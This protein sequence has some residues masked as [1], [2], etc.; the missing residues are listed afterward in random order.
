[1]TA[2]VHVVGTGL[3]GTSV[4][5]ALQ[6]IA[7]VVLSDPDPEARRRSV[8]R[9]AGRA[10]DGA[11][12][13]RL[14]VIASPPSR[15]AG[16]IQRLQRLDVGGTF[17]H[18]ASVQ[19]PVLAEVEA[20]GCD[21]SSICGGH[22]LAG[23]ERSGPDAALADL[24]AGRPWVI[25]PGPTTTAAAQ[26]AVR[27]LAQA[28]GAEPVVMSPQE[29]DRA[30]ALVS[31][32]PQVAASAVAAQLVAPGARE[33]LRIAGPGLQDTTRVAASDPELWVEVLRGN[34][35]HVAP[36]VRALAGDLAELADALDALRAGGPDPAGALAQVDALLRRGG[37]GRRHVPVKRG[38]HDADFVT[39]DVSVPD[40]PGQLA[41]LLVSAAA[42]GVNVEDVH[43][44]HLRGRPRGVVQ[45]L[46]HASSVEAA[47]AALSAAGWDVVG[48][49]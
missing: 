24:F 42:A 14:V 29:H 33:A 27:E 8:A 23:R 46:V 26:D 30:V 2:D 28:C 48:T 32:L 39:V 36:L 40:R 18:V 13:A 5:L 35:E 7:D 21:A 43:V 38:E 3:I 20:L 12:P 15:I 11:E 6:G 37:D 31:H 9:G 10:W 4:G 25:C 22:P 19:A 44:E 16:V 34:A 45:L 1:M 17:S 41:G 47:Q 49:G